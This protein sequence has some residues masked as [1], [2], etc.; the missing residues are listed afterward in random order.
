VWTASESPYTLTGH[1]LIPQGSSLTIESGVQIELNDRFIQVDGT[2]RVLGTS[3]NPVSIK[4]SINMSTPKIKFTSTCVGWDE[5]T[6]LGTIVRNATIDGQSYATFFIEIKG[7]SPRIQDCQISSINRGGGVIFIRGGS[8][9]IISNTIVGG[10]DGISVGEG[11]EGSPQLIGNII[12]SSND[13]FG[14]I[15]LASRTGG[16]TIRIERNVITNYQVGIEI[17]I[18]ESSIDILSNNINGSKRA[19]LLLGTSDQTNPEQ[20]LKVK[21]NAIYNNNYNVQLGWPPDFDLSG[22]WWGTTDTTAIEAKF[23]HKP[24]D[25]RQ[26]TITYV[27]FLTSMPTDVPTLP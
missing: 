19:G 1:L 14:G 12:Q 6:G 17:N 10:G 26:G 9:Q 15:R 2:L 7:S 16:G 11:S 25:F 8:P 13:D 23:Y 27:P 21:G 18:G 20:F 3:N 22:N 24:Q 4:G 5:S